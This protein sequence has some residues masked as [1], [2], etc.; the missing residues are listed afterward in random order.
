MH[1]SKMREILITKLIV[2]LIFPGKAQIK[3]ADTSLSA[4][5]DSKDSCALYHQLAQHKIIPGTNHSIP[6][7]IAN[8]IVIRPE[9]LSEHLIDSIYMIKCPESFHSYGNIAAAGVLYLKTKQS[10]ESVRIT[11][12]VKIRQSHA[13]EQ[14][15]IYAVNGYLFADE[16]LMLSRRAIKKIDIMK[17]YRLPPAGINEEVTVINIWTLTRREIKRLND[18]PKPCRGIGLSAVIKHA[19]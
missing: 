4:S 11:S 2:F 1:L 13:S 6:L 12:L 17:N 15:I 7:I 16:S 18:I 14:K 8:G 19:R 10:F 5:A 3:L 9:D